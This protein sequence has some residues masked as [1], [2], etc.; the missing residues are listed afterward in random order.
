MNF[1]SWNFLDTDFWYYFDS[2]Y[3]AVV[4]HKL[5]WGNIYCLYW[6]TLKLIATS[7]IGRLLEIR[8]EARQDSR[9]AKSSTNGPAHGPGLAWP[10][11]RS[12]G[13]QLMH[14]GMQQLG[15]GTRRESSRP[16]RDRDETFVAL[17][18][19]SRRWS[20]SF[21]DCSYRPR[22]YLSRSLFLTC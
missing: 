2:F 8:K 6:T 10:I 1:T 22:W 3:T 5:E 13:F 14:Y 7:G 11:T 4:L 15:M 12:S 16:R 9:V 21:I 20:T 17:E 18:T 19:W